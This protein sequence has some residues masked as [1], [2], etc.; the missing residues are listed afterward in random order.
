VIRLYRKYYRRNVIPNWSIE[1]KLD[2][3]TNTGFKT[4]EQGRLADCKHVVIYKKLIFSSS[5]MLF[6]PT[7]CNKVVGGN[8]VAEVFTTN[9]FCQSTTT[10]STVLINVLW[11]LIF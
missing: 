9:W 5:C 7:Q 3:K 6:C 8:K 11:L 1:L 10:D 4:W 2:K